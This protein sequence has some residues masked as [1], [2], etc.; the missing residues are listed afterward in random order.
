MREP[1]EDDGRVVADMSG[2]E[3]P[4]LLG[5]WFGIGRRPGRTPAER[6]ASAESSRSR[7]AFGQGAPDLSGEERRAALRG[8][9]KASLLIVFIYLGAFAALIALLLFLWR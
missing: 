1:F 6:N 4:S 9:M 7:N 8:V 5:S 3:K 2:V